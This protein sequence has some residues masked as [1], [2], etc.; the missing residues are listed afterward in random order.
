MDV[1]A[2]KQ[3]EKTL[4]ESVTYLAEAQRLTHTGSAAWQVAGRSAVPLR[5]IVSHIWLGSK[6]GPSAWE[7]A[8]A[9]ASG[10]SSQVGRYNRP[11]HKGKGG[12][13]R[14]T[15]NSSSGRHFSS[16]LA[17]SAILSLTHRG[18][19]QFVCTM[20]DVTE[21]KVAEA[22][23]AS[24]N[25]RLIEAQENERTRIAGELHDDIGQRL[26]LL[27]VQL[28]QLQEDTLILPEVRSRMGE[29]Q[30][31]IS[32]IADDI[33]FLSHELHSAKL[34]YLGIAGAIRGLSARALRAAES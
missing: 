26:A 1:T 13:R 32:K 33:Q 8:A 9:D 16:T 22:A 20:M 6:E 15:P 19:E 29:F 7:T 18:W 3:V 27:A 5:G 2:A 12:L 4:K 10:G 25:R 28:Q 30:K 11:S 24:V 23:L 31:Q 21:R 34:Q 14:G 17:P